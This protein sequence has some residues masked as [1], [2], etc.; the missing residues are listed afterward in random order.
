[1]NDAGCIFAL[2]ERLFCS[3]VGGWESGEMVGQHAHSSKPHLLEHAG[4]VSNVYY[5]SMFVI[6]VILADTSRTIAAIR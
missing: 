5:A 4:L 6:T 2:F 3:N 1:M